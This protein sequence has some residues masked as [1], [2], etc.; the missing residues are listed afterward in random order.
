MAGGMFERV[1]SYKPKKKEGLNEKNEATL[2]NKS[3]PAETTKQE[4]NF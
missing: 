2:I 1:A 4:R 3:T